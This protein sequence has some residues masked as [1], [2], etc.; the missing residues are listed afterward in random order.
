MTSHNMHQN[1]LESYDRFDFSER[2]KAVA[3][4][5]LRLRTA[6]DRQVAEHLGYADMNAVRPTITHLTQRGAVREV[7][8]IR[9]PVTGRK[10][11]VSALLPPGGIQLEIFTGSGA[12]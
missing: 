7:G 8:A 3:G 5:L 9:C 2:E 11:R 10:V 1:S 12:P 6:T 4:A